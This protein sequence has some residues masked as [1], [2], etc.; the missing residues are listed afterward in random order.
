MTKI[1]RDTW[2]IFQQNMFI[3]LKNPVFAVVGLFNPLCFLIL[4][5]PL[6]KSLAT[7][8]HFGSGDPLTMFLPGLLI[9]MSLYATSYVGF[10]LIGE[11]RV[12]MLERFWVSPVSRVALVLG[13]ALRDVMVLLVQSL[14]LIGFSYISGLKASGAGII[15]TLG[16][17]ALVG[18][19][20]SSLSYTLALLLKDE[21]ALAAVINFFLLPTQ[22]LA[23]VTLPL[24]LGPKWIQTVAHYNPLYYAVEGSRALFAGNFSDQSIFISFTLMILLSFLTSWFLIR[25]YR[26]NAV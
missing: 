10:G 23:G 19:V 6:L 2:L 25:T 11:I 16:L 8:P 4:F 14:L 5:A 24:T 22:F 26:T 21:K 13:R 7:L 15:I 3:T 20:L 1:L 12:G 18:L 9:M 17:V